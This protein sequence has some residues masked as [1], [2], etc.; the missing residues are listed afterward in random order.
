M[1][2]GIVILQFRADERKEVIPAEIGF[3]RRDSYIAV[4]G[5]LHPCRDGQAVDGGD[6]G[7]GISGEGLAQPAAFGIGLGR[8]QLGI[9]SGD[10]YTERTR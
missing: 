5:P 6:E 7:F 2:H 8:R 4:G 3:G 1:H 9:P 10:E